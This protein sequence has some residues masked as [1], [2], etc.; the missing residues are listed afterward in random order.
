MTITNA[1]LD[2]LIGNAKTQED[3]FGKDGIINNLTKRLIERMLEG[4]MTL[5]YQ[6]YDTAGDNIRVTVKQPRC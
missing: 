5:G 2:E 3:V 4:E 6:K 1:M